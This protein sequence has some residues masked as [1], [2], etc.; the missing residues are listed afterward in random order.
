ML[1]H[2]NKISNLVKPKTVFKNVE[3][4]YTSEEM[5]SAIVKNQHL[6]KKEFRPV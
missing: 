2:F 6:F 1:S 5:R 4:S 3:I